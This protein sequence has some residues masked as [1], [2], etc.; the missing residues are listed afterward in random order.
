MHYHDMRRRDREITDPQEIANVL[1]NGKYAS[2]GLVDGDEPYVVTMSYGWDTEA[3]RL[4]FHAAHEGRKID[5]IRKNARACVTVVADAGYNH[6]ECEHPFE[7]VVMFG[8]MRI[9]EDDAEKR[10][11]ILTLVSHLESEPQ[12][13]WDS[14]SWQLEQRIEGFSALVFEIERTTAKRGR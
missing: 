9:V 8:R 14:R 12:E 11:A 13:Y 3:D 10:H 5:A 4:Y 6:G 2:V 7:S 1:R